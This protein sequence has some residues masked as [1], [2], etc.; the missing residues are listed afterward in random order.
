M[1]RRR[2]RIPLNVF[3]NSRLVGRLNRQRSGAIEFRYD[4]SWLDRGHTLPISISLPLREDRYLGDPVTAVFDNLLPDPEPVRRR[5]AE[6]VGAEGPDAYSLLTK[7]GRDCVGALQFLPEGQDPGPAGSVEGRLLDDGEIAEKIRNL[8]TRPLGLDDDPEFRISIAGAQEKTALLH[9]NGRWHVPRGTTATTH[10]MK[11]QIGVLPNGV[12]LS[13]SVENEYLCLRLTAA[14]GLP[15]ATVEIADFDGEQR[16]ALGRRAGEQP[17]DVGVLRTPQHVGVEPR[18][19]EKL[20]VVLA[21][22]VRRGDDERQR[23]RR[24]QGQRDGRTVGR[25]RVGHGARLRLADGRRRNARPVYG[26][27]AAGGQSRWVDG[28]V[29]GGTGHRTNGWKRSSFQGF[30]SRPEPCCEAAFPTKRRGRTLHCRPAARATI[31]QTTSGAGRWARR[32]RSSRTSTCGAASR[33]AFAAAATLGGVPRPLHQV[34]KVR[35]LGRDRERARADAARIEQVAH[36]AA[37]LVDDARERAQLGRVQ[38]LRGVRQDGG[39][40][41]AQL[42]APGSETRCASARSRRAAQGPA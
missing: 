18:L 13:R 24:R 41:R 27:A 30:T 14:L 21:P 11:P 37:L 7:L 26:H 17:V 42:V 15:S 28:G 25:G 5:I 22:A 2:A 38:G 8:A 16:R 32:L 33:S 19:G 10:I 12:D 29:A 6:R 36:A 40:R 20:R 9:W 3:L 1:A 4:R 31:P 35:W 34:A 39:Q 23:G